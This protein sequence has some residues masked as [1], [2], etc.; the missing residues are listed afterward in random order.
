MKI[1]VITSLIIA[2]L[3]ILSFQ[4]M[5]Q[6]TTGATSGFIPTWTLGS[7]INLG[8]ALLQ[9]IMVIT[10]FFFTV[11]YMTRDITELK[12]MTGKLADSLQTMALTLARMESYDRRLSRLEEAKS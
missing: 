8:G 12:L 4:A 9:G 11:K 5:S 3:A 2:A 10:G 6:T 7:V 1:A